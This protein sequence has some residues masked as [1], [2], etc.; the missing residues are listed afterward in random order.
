MRR[1]VG[2]GTPG[3]ISQ[4]G[5]GALF[6]T[7]RGKTHTQMAGGGGHRSNSGGFLALLRGGYRYTH[8][9]W[10]GDS[11]QQHHG[12]AHGEAFHKAREEQA[13]ISLKT[14][15][16]ATD[17][18]EPS[19]VAVR[20]GRALAEAFHA[21]L[22]ILH[23]VPDSLALPWATMADGL[24]MADTQR[25]WERD[26]HERLERLLPESERQA[27][28]AVLVT[29]TGDP[30]RRVTGYA[31]ES[32]ADIV[33]LGTHGRGPV[34]HMLMGSVAERVVRSA[35]CPVLTVRHPQHEFVTEA[36]R[37]VQQDTTAPVG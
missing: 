12:R 28:H 2:R 35:P 16:V 4:R 37:Q 24:A 30:V 29:R 26:A 32:G 20:Y 9:D 6:L 19:E 36:G 18:S 13:M 23:V 27:V 11:R 15:L 34:A 10:E 21:S 1:V 3:N 7:A 14:I 5:L 31:V 33:V 17:F 22:H 8:C 25:Q